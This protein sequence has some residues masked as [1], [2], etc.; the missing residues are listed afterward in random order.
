M[1]IIYYPQNV[2][3][4][5]ILITIIFAFEVGFVYGFIIERRIR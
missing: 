2:V 5:A 4:L 3:M 1:T